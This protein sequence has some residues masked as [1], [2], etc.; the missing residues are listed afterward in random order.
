MFSELRL[1]VQR[2]NLA[3]LRSESR[4]LVTGN[5]S[6]MQHQVIEFYQ[7]NLQLARE[8]GNRRDEMSA[9]AS[10]GRAYQAL[11][12]YAK[13]IEF[14][15]QALNIAAEL[16]DGRAERQTLKHLQDAR[17]PQAAK[18][19]KAAAKTK[20]AAGQT[21]A[22]KSPAKSRRR[23]SKKQAAKKQTRKTPSSESASSPIPQS[24]REE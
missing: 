12:E 7:Q 11:E 4:E 2:E 14:Y 13:A 10:L 5:L 20:T 18:T 1:I 21:S 9:L 15:E 3:R 16:G 23:S 22:K 17:N 8:T 6:L 24:G 19:A